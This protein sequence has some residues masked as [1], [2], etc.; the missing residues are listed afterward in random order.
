MRTAEDAG[1]GAAGRN[2]PLLFD[3][4]VGILGSVSEIAA[5]PGAPDFFHAEARTCNVGALG[6]AAGRFADGAAA[7]DRST[8]IA[9]AVQRT[10]ARYCAALY[11]R[12]GLP[13]A[14]TADAGFR[15]VPPGD[16]ALFSEAQLGRAG[17]PFVAFD[18]DTPVRWTGA[19]DLASGENVH[20]PA[21]FVWFPYF[22]LRTGGDLPIVEPSA[23]GLACGEGVASATLAGL[24]DVVARD[25]AA[26]FW[27]T[28]TPPPQIRAEALP[29]AAR[30][31]IARFVLAGARA[32]ILDVTTN[33]RIPSF[34]AVATSEEPD[35]PAY[36]FAM[37]AD[38][39]PEA[40]IELALLRLADTRRLAAAAMRSRPPPSP[41]YDWEDV[42]EWADHLT[43][44]AAHAN[45]RACDF[46]LSSEDRRDIADYD[47][48][49]FGDADAELEAALSAVLATGCRAYA[50]NLTSED[51]G[52]LGFSVVRVIV[53]GY[54]PLVA[55]HRARALGGSRLYDVPQK[56]GFRGIFRGSSGNSAPHPFNG[57][58]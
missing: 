46:A 25:A 18:P 26:L 15:C 14:S 7:T 56:L 32:T 1:G 48:H 40:A 52:A 44:A 23:T 6:G 45:R 37:A 54:Q 36:A 50:A 13:L 41:A 21:A 31:L 51:M 20:V 28:A 33:N 53:P 27:Q 17:F 38:L 49:P 57:E 55:G 12:D 58:A 42:T 24:Y 4:V 34:V 9:S 43:F 3:P 10:V 19:V 2:F 8:A 39:D 5:G 30:G 22:W 29:E 16:F 11:Q 47:R 35:R